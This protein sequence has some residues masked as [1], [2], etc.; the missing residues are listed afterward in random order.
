MND[1]PLDINDLWQL[2]EDFSGKF[3][4]EDIT[5]NPVYDKTT[6]TMYVYHSYQLQTIASSTSN[7]EP[8]M[9]KDAN[10]ELYGM[11][12]LTYIDDD[13]YV[14]YGKEHNYVLSKLFTGARPSMINNSFG[15]NSEDSEGRNFKGQVIWQDSTGKEY[16]LIGNEAQL[17]AIGSDDPVYTA[18][19]QAYLSLGWHVDEDKNGNPI[20]L[21][22]GDADLSKEQNG[23]QDYKFQDISDPSKDLSG[24]GGIH[25]RGKC[26][27]IQVGSDAGKIDPNFDIDKSGHK[28]TANENYIIFRN[29]D[30]SSTGENS[31]GND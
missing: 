8:V 10:P 21:Y 11:G 23:K 19:Y 3:V 25:S 26:G 13:N 4:S 1:I 14:T 5:E 28:Y 22:S 16:I 12:Q 2:P 31:D 7:Q 6:D 29:I 17:R 15:Q 20:M 27:Q 9:S 18:V 30:F 24:I